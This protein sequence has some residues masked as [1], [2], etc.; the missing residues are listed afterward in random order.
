MVEDVMVFSEG[1][2]GRGRKNGGNDRDNEPKN[3]NSQPTRPHGHNPDRNSSTT[4]RPR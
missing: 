2:G 1:K 4:A 3:S